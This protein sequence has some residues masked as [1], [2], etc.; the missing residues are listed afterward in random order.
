MGAKSIDK[1][2]SLYEIQITLKGD[3]KQG[4]NET[5]WGDNE[6]KRFHLE[7]PDMLAGPFWSAPL[8]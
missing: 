8:L 7:R 2:S 4:K 5:H 3:F 1:S 6:Q